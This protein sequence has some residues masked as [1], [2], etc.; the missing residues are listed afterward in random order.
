MKRK[1]ERSDYPNG[2]ARVLFI[3]K[4]WQ[5]RREEQTSPYVN[6]KMGISKRRPKESGSPLQRGI[7][8]GGERIPPSSLLSLAIRG[9]SMGTCSFSLKK[10]SSFYIIIYYYKLSMIY[11][12]GTLA[13]CPFLR[14]HKKNQKPKC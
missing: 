14:S 2:E 6:V 13:Y 9:P 4:G 7:A 1:L 3:R 11:I 10:G 5:R 8:I 12:G